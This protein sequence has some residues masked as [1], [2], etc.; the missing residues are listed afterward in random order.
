MAYKTARRF[1]LRKSQDLYFEQL[2]GLAAAYRAKQ[3]GQPGTPLPVDFPHLGALTAARYT[4]REDL[5]G[6]D[7]LELTRYANLSTRDARAVLTAF[8]ALP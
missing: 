7:V 5:D 8:A 1:F 6:A 4:T 2:E 3:D